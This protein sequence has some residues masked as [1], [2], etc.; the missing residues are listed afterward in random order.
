[1]KCICGRKFDSERALSGH[2]AHCDVYELKRKL[3][4][5]QDNNEI[6]DIVKV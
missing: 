4:I 1:M 3:K 6:Y 2:K 5:L